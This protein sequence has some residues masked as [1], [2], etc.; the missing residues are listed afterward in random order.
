[1]FSKSMA[2]REAKWCTYQSYLSSSLSRQEYRGVT[3]IYND[4]LKRL[5]LYT[6]IYILLRVVFGY[7]F[8]CLWCR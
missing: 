3:I 2:K 4:K 8:G 6:Y 1:M 7:L 5:F